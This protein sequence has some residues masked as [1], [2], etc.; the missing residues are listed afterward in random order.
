MRILLATDGSIEADMAEVVLTRLPFH[1]PEVVVAMVV[2]N[3]GIVMMPPGLPCDIDDGGISRLQRDVAERTVEHICN[4]L[5]SS[6]YKASPLVAT[7]DVAGQLLELVQA[8]GIDL[9][10]AGSRIEGNFRA[11][12]LGSVSRKLALYS[13]SSV[14][15]AHHYR[16]K[17]SEGSVERL[18][19][20]PQLDVLLAVDGSPG[21]DLAVE[22]LAALK[23]ARFRTLYV[24]TVAPHGSKVRTKGGPETK[25][26][27]EGDE[28]AHSVAEEAARKLAACAER[29]VPIIA[30]GRPSA[31]I[32]RAAADHDVDIIMM[33]A[34][35][36]GA[37]ER[38]I[39][40][41]C[42]Y[43]TVTN[44]PCSVLILRSPLAMA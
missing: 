3:P 43:E 42:A 25:F 17:A 36:H 28:V 34:S 7:G 40:G 1:D 38:L 31:A 9:V 33:G 21:G 5:V 16:Q 26:A 11:F 41:S 14:L 22:A 4:R 27:L 32:I 44:A 37:L 12:F 8:G 23:S 10:A 2:P 35:H 30:P 13:Q 18:L 20:R 24:L 39:V 29:V 19:S 6:G 15:V